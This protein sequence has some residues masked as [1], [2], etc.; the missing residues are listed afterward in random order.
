MALTYTEFG[1][2]IGFVPLPSDLLAAIFGLTV[3]YLVLVQYVKTWFYRG[4]PL[5]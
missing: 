2:L 5:M 1:R 3:T 4:H